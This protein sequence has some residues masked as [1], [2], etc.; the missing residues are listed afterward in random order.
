MKNYIFIVLMFFFTA[1]IAMSADLT[2]VG[3]GKSKKE[4]KQEALAD[5]S[6][7]VRV[8]VK[9]KF[10]SKAIGNSDGQSKEIQQLITTES[11]LP[12]LGAQFDIIFVN[13]E[14]MAE[15]Y[16]KRD[17]VLRLY[18]DAL[19]SAKY[20]VNRS[21][22]LL[23]VEDEESVSYQLLTSILT[24]IEQYRK[25]KA[26]A[27]L[28]GATDFPKLSIGESEVRAKIL[29]LSKSAKTLEFGA[30]LLSSEIAHENVYVY[31]A[32]PYQSHEVTPF[33]AV[34]K[35]KIFSGLNKAT[36][37]PQKADYIMVGRYLQNDKGL[38]VTYTLND[39]AGI[40]L[41][42]VVVHFAPTAYE[43]YRTEPET[44]DFDRLLHDGVVVSNDFRAE[45]A[46]HKGTHGLVFKHKD[47]IELLIKMN[48]A[49]YFYI[50]GHVVKKSGRYSYIVELSEGAGNRK[51]IHY[52]NADDANKWVSLGEF[53]AIP[54]FGVESLQVIAST[55]DL[56]DHIPKNRLQKSSGLYVL[57]KNPKQSIMKTRAIGKKQIRERLF[58]ESVLMFTTME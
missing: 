14:F 2:G 3:Y 24:E 20:K 36:D 40:T 22:Q 54:P 23:S 55:K 38:D 32:T 50:V 51:F 44:I 39:K 15:A 25:Y 37:L 16:L 18:L 42:T 58:A 19:R 1:S 4:A 28:L 12:I 17:N 56:M 46:T 41:K 5:L 26:V 6:S 33:S 30:S 45:V 27:L 35:D 43:G 13:N 34:L 29:K 49:G 9:S 8:E 48:Q 31:P 10:L 57:S 7:L 47:S 52:L 21:L 11:D 53:E